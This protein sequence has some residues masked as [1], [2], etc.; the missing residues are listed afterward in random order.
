MSRISRF[1]R[2]CSLLLGASRV[3]ALLG[4]VA[5]A[6]CSSTP[7]GTAGAA[8]SVIPWSGQDQVAT[9]GTNVAMPIQVRVTDAAGN[10]VTGA[11]VTLSST[12]GTLGETSGVSGDNGLLQTNFTTGTK[13]GIDSVT[14]TVAGVPT[15]AVFAFTAIAADPATLAIVAG[16]DQTAAAGASLQADLAVQVLD[17]YGNPVPNAPVIWTADAGQV[18]NSSVTTDA[19]GIAQVLFTLP[20]TPG[21]DT[22]VAVVGTAPPADFTE[23]AN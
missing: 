7:T 2:S 19:S 12:A 6:A 13:A 17:K 18:S 21:T 1:T 22:V 9:V 23:I 10:P 15:P 3:T 5:I 16:N 14:V 20:A 8:A 11:T 4:A